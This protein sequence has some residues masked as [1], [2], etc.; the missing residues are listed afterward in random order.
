MS[1][2]ILHANTN[3]TNIK[4]QS[5]HNYWN[6]KF[7]LNPYLTQKPKTQEQEAALALYI[8]QHSVIAPVDHLRS[9]CK[10]KFDD[11]MSYTQMKL[12]RTKCTSIIKNVSA[13][14]FVED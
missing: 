6:A 9:L 2:L 5:N 3:K 1:N 12:Y 7:H 4:Q 11:S 8:S 13:T 14:H 10:N